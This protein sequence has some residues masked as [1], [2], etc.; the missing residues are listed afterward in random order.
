MVMQS[1]MSCDHARS[2]SWTQVVPIILNM[3]AACRYT[4]RYDVTWPWK[5]KVVIHMYLDANILKTETA[6]GKSINHVTHDVT[7]PRKVKSWP[8]YVF[9]PLSRQWL[10]IETPI[11]NLYLGYRMGTWPL[12]SRTLERQGHCPIHFD[13]NISKTVDDRDSV[14]VGH[15]RK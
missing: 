6:C 5:V 9:G 2:S 10:E 7:C 12:T 3:A 13:A 11:G 1:M 8:Q 4:L 15:N 14:P